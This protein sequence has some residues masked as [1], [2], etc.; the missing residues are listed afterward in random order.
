MGTGKIS[1]IAGQPL[2][3]GFYTFLKLDL[4]QSEETNDKEGGNRRGKGRGWGG[5]GR[6]RGQHHNNHKTGGHAVGTPPNHLIHSEQPASAKQ[7]P[8]PR[9]PDGTRGFTMGRGKPLSTPISG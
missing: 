3:L 5:R 1:D 4:C 9:M 2:D 8:G 6:G 7:P